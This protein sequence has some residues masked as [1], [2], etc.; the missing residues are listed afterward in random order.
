MLTL[1]L[2]IAQSQMRIVM[3]AQTVV[4]FDVR[5]VYKTLDGIETTE[6]VEQWRYSVTETLN[7]GAAKLKVERTLTKMIVDG[8]AI[9]MKPETSETTEDRSPAGDVRNRKPVETLDSVYELRLLRIADVSYPGVAV[10]AGSAWQKAFEAT[11]YGVPAGTATWL[12]ESE[13][14]GMLK[15]TFTYAEKDVPSPITAEGTFTVSRKDGWPQELAFKAIN[16]YQP[17]DEEKLP[18]VFEFSLKRR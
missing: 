2:V 15:G 1:A 17:G 7:G 6:F 18:T 8:T 3:D 10:G 9:I 5:Q 12:V 16:T 13:A 14:D 4:A 11:D